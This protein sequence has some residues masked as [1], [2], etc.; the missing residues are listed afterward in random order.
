[1]YLTVHTQATIKCCCM[2]KIYTEGMVFL[3]HKSLRSNLN[4]VQVDYPTHSK[5]NVCHTT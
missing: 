3:A 1:M 4:F 5:Q 2:V